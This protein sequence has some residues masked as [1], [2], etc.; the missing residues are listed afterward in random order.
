[1]ILSHSQGSVRQV[2][3]F[4]HARNWGQYAGPVIG[5]IT[6]R[7]L[8]VSGLFVF[9]QAPI[10]NGWGFPLARGREFLP[11]P[12]ERESNLAHATWRR[13]GEFQFPFSAIFFCDVFH[14][15]SLQPPLTP[16]PSQG[17]ALW[18]DA[19]HCEHPMH[20]KDWYWCHC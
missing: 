15:P 6:A 11:I 2:A 20:Q 13:G 1:M 5:P 3:R 16:P 14:T 12:R 18:P 8:R 19:A 17:H 10:T 7:R 9:F 4:L